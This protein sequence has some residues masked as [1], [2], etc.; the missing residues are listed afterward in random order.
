MENNSDLYCSSNN[1]FLSYCGVSV[2]FR[3]LDWESRD[4]SF[5]ELKADGSFD[6]ALLKN[7]DVTTFIFKPSS[8]IFSVYLRVP[9]STFKQTGCALGALPLKCQWINLCKH[10]KTWGSL[11]VTEMHHF[12]KHTA[13]C[14]RAFSKIECYLNMPDLVLNRIVM[15][16][17][18]LAV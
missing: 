14:N 4:I 1:V 7:G 3:T 15:F 5:A 6:F 18:S 8:Y 12:I 16:H 9:Q 13:R 2:A 10:F 11:T 17:I